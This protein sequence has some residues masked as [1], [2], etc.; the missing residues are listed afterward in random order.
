MNL[1]IK[2]M[3]KQGKEVMDY[4]EGQPK[5]VQALVTDYIVDA[6][7]LFVAADWFDDDVEEWLEIHHPDQLENYRKEYM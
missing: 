7:N 5:Y 4:L 1:T 3:S 6:P 2:E